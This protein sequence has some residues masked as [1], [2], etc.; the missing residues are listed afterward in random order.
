MKHILSFILIILL[1]SCTK[2][3][4]NKALQ[5]MGVY[6]DTIYLTTLENNHSEIVFF[7]MHH[8]GTE[9]FYN[10]VK[11][12]V[13]S[14]K[15]L[16]F[17]FYTESITSGEENPEKLDTALRKF[18]KI[19]GKPVPAKGHKFLFDSIVSRK[20]IKLKKTIVE[21]P[22]PLELVPD[23]TVR[24]NVDVNIQQIIT[25]Y[26]KNYGIIKLEEC[27]FETSIYEKTTCYN[28][29]TIKKEKKRFNDVIVLYRNK[30]II[31]ELKKDQVKHNR[32]AIIYGKKHFE[33]IEEELLKL[34]YKKIEQTE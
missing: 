10:D 5:S 26:E 18:R 17:I 19:Y 11:I 29:T 20:K 25:Y 27:D 7:P 23:S 9:A 33:G 6:D 12:K 34:G 21:Q 24:K 31:S 16:G 22:S 1:S 32:I 2:L 14:L 4:F 15:N 30:H 3:L 8:I 13:D 28:I